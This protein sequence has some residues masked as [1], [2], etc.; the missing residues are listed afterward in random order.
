MPN[1]FD[2][3]RISELIELGGDSAYAAFVASI[4]V[5]SRCD[6]RGTLRR[7]TGTPHTAQSLHRQTGISAK[8]FDQMFAIAE[9]SGL[10]S[11][12]EADGAPSELGANPAPPARH[13]TR[14]DKQD[15]TKQTSDASRRRGDVLKLSQ[16]NQAGGQDQEPDSAADVSTSRRPGSTSTPT[17]PENKTRE[18]Y[19]PA[20]PFRFAV[21]RAIV[22][23]WGLSPQL[24]TE[25]RDIESVAAG[26][27][28]KLGD[29][30]DDRD[31]ALEQ[32]NRRRKAYR[33]KF[34]NAADTPRAVLKHWD[35]LKPKKDPA[36][37]TRSPWSNGKKIEKL[38]DEQR[39]EAKRI[40]DATHPFKNDKTKQTAEAI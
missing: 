29:A 25:I 20:L 6:P 7:S 2:G 31:Q 22:K 14:Q 33:L 15:R 37:A 34:P 13:S 40:R 21:A 9:K 27:K 30:A 23:A 3:D 18:A 38:T 5:A 32:I 8:A 24:D 19:L 11:Q 26:Y 17:T 1:K 35:Y 12:L 10:M 4:L 36:P 28:I 39:A 16:P